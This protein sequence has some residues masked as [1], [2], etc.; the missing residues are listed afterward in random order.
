LKWGPHKGQYWPFYYASSTAFQIAGTSIFEAQSAEVELAF[1]DATGQFDA[2]DGDR[3]RP[4][5][6]ETR[7]ARCDAA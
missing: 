1:V 4:E 6:F 2:G 7:T 5:P 3:G